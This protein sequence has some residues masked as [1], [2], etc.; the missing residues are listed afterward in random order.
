[1]TRASWSNRLAAW[2][3]GIAVCAGFSQV[4]RSVAKSLR[5]DRG[6]RSSAAPGDASPKRLPKQESRLGS[7]RKAEVKARYGQLPLAFEPNVGQTDKRV[8]Y[9]ARG[10]GYT[11]FLTGDKTV[12]KLSDR[13][14]LG[15]KPKAMQKQ[16]SSSDVIALHF[17]GS[18]L[19]PQ[20]SS[21]DELPGKS[22]YFTG[23]DPAQWRTDVSQ[24]GKVTMAEFYPGIGL[25]Y[26]GKGRQLEQDWVVSPGADPDRIEI[27]VEGARK[28]SL[29]SNGDL[30]L[31]LSN[32]ELR[33]H[34]PVIY[35]RAGS[36]QNDHTPV[37]GGFMLAGDRVRFRLGPYDLTK[38]L[39]IDPVLVYSS[40]L[41]GSS[42]DHANAVAIDSAGDAYIAGDTSSLD[43]PVTTGVLQSSCAPDFA[44]ICERSAFVAEINPTGT[45]ELYST[46]LGGGSNSAVTPNASQVAFG[47]AVDSA[48]DAFVTGQTTSIQFPVQ[49]AYQSTCVLDAN[50][51]CFDAFV[52]VIKAGGSALLYSSYLG[53]SGVDSGNAISIDGSG[54]AYIGG[55]TASTDFPV[56]AGV[57]QSKCG[58]DGQC[59][60]S[61]GTLQPDAFVAKINT[62]AS[63]ASS[64]VYSTYLGGSGADYGTSIAIDSSLNAYVT[65]STLSTDLPATKGAFQSSCKLDSTSVCEGEPYVAELNPTA[66]GLV[67]LTYVG[68]SGGGGLDTAHGLALDSSNNA[69]VVGQTGWTD[70]PVTSGAFQT[71]CGTDGQCNPVN[72]VPT[73]HVFV[74]KLNSAGSALVY[75]TYLGGSGYDFATSV[76]V[77][78]SNVP[79]VVGGTYSS[80]FPVANAT[81]SGGVL[82]GG[83]DAFVTALNSQGTGLIMSTYLGGTGNDV[84][85]GIARDASN[86]VFVT[87]S[88]D[89]TDFPTMGPFQ[90]TNKGQT[91][92][93]VTEISS[94][95]AAVVTLAPSTLTFAP[96]E[97]S[98]PSAAQTLTLSNIGNAALTITSIAASGALPRPIRA[99]LHWRLQRVA[100]SL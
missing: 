98:T 36:S 23:Q 59:N 15:E 16:S 13:E 65:G 68:G 78:G 18:N 22:N 34:K 62:R 44:G 7:L 38:P 28:L 11:I 72:G 5:R 61:S 3:L 58:T 2:I 67:Y 84:G 69:Y 50:N 47:I 35:Q 30:R 64:L 8:R 94:V 75:S 10:G 70:F 21:L 53:G 85:N 99:A 73:P 52:S 82:A 89:S 40:Y 54:N 1:M 42:V 91:D 71:S 45:A 63:G 12:L 41:G 37:S 81:S 26:Y 39:I 93:F 25:T 14:Q 51:V 92:A 60:S 77:D 33:W 95:T 83:E 27:D 88:T 43:F 24:Y 4:Q 31:T 74:S 49:N 6:S 57:V 55:Q 79:Y 100:P 87:G 97:V 86:N 19:S 32:G 96:Q 46:Y 29:A 9:L 80:D 17:R 48:G 90:A 20:V 76:S 66:T 56:T